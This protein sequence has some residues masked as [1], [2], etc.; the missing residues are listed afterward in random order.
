[1]AVWPMAVF[2]KGVRS[3]LLNGT[4]LKDIIKELAQIIV[5][6]QPTEICG[7]EES[8][9]AL[10]I[11]LFADP[12]NFFKMEAVLLVL[13][14]NFNV[15][16]STNHKNFW[17]KAWH[18]WYPQLYAHV[19]LQKTLDKKPDVYFLMYGLLSLLDDG[20]IHEAPLRGFIIFVN[21]FSINNKCGKLWNEKNNAF[22]DTYLLS[23]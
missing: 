2:Q 1:M 16:S 14:S 17:N 4:P 6:V 12:D 22:C 13:F 15:S 21:Q 3:V 8:I 19:V 9:Y 7:I 23:G 11:G 5:E 10:T 18:E 20:D